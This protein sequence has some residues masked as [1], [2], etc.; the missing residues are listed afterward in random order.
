MST[1]RYRVVL[2][3]ASGGLGQA[4]ARALAMHSSAMVLAGRDPLKLHALQQ[5]IAVAAPHVALRVVAGDLTEAGTQQ[6][7]LRQAESLGDPIDLLINAAGINEF[8][9]FESQ[10]RASVERIIAIDLLAPM[11]LTQCMLPLLKRPPRAQVINVGSVFGYLGYP[12]FASYCAAKFGL[13]GFSQALR[14]ELS[15]T[16]VAVRYFAPRATRTPLITPAIS[17]MNRELKTRED[18]PEA[19]ARLLV[20]FVAGSGWDRKLGFPERLYVLL[21]DL[22]PRVNDSAIRRQLRVIR[23]HFGA[24]RQG[25]DI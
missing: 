18:A 5:T 16:N 14:R 11:Q 7:V 10:P 2:T 3:G 17:A 15:D 9:P 20:R 22:A 19:V 1:H 23:R 24:N 4:F 25:V 12:G 21:N 8:H 6:E 13:R